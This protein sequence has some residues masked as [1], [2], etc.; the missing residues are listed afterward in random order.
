[1][2]TQNVHSM[3]FKYW[4]SVA[5]SDTTLSQQRDKSMYVLGTLNPIPFDKQNISI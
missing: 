2:Q 5:E 4:V 1:M 3:L